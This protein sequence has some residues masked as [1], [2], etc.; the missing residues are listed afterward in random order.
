[1]NKKKILPIDEIFTLAVEN[2][3]K[4]K[5]DV[6]L[7][8]YNQVFE[9]N[10]NYPG[11]HNNLGVLFQGFGEHQK[12]VSCYE[13]A[14]ES[15]PH[16]VNSY[17]NLGAVLKKI[18]DYEKAIKC[19]DKVIQIDPNNL[20]I[21]SNL[22]NLL[23]SISIK[24][25]DL[26]LERLFI[27]LFK[28]KN[29]NHTRISNN[30][31][32]L[33]F[34]KSDYNQIHKVVNSNSKLLSNEII[35][36]ILKDELFI[37]ILQKSL[38]TDIFV[39]KF[40]TKIRYEILFTLKNSNKSILSN[41]ID[42]INSLAEQCWFNEYIFNQSENEINYINKLKEEIQN[43]QNINEL[44]IMILGCYMPLNGIGTILN[45]ILNYKSTSILFNNLLNLQIKEPLKELELKKSIKSLGKIVDPVSQ[46][47][48][49]QYEE[50][51]FPR[52]RSAHIPLSG[53][54]SKNLNQDIKPNNIDLNNKLISPNVLIAGCGTGQHIIGVSRYQNAKILAVDI[55]L[56]SLAY[57]KRKTEE[58]N[59]KNI[60]YLHVDILQ[61]RNLNR[62]FDVIECGG[63]LH[64]MKDPVAGLKILLDILEP[65]GFLKLGL[66]S[67]IARQHIIEAREL[68]NKMNLLKTNDGIRIFRQLIIDKD[69]DSLFVKKIIHSADFFSTSNIKDL[70]FHVQ[71]HLFTIPEIFKILNDFNLEFLGFLFSNEFYKKRYIKSF[72]DDKK[73]LSL[74]NWHEHEIKN[75]DTFIA[76]YQFWVRKNDN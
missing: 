50:Y 70:L 55:S 52:W 64:H 42:F 18:G 7:K 35:Q 57:A 68:I 73:N 51:P 65:N 34:L 25:Y 66:Y 60:E 26:I 76:M 30:A 21:I 24:K 11:I 27:Y 36:K 38:I 48:R 29:I 46:K 3:Q 62:K 54:F 32:L 74:D 39:E 22:S 47:V 14:I 37:L 33:L 13:K 69:E 31:K 71:E 59:I 16:D 56:S 19:Y 61:L 75:P 49:K 53:L 15:N 44:E 28:R 12:A 41:F 40:L 4:N 1:M 8:L 17:N 2:H 5:H 67:Q 20:V 72:P 6:A 63:T 10:P 9:I 23:I 58:L 43:K 45:K